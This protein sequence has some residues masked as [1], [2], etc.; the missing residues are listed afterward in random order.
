MPHNYT[1]PTIKTLFAQASS[2]AYPRCNEPLVFEDRGVTTVVAQI[3]HIRSEKL[4]G[5]R[6]DP[7]YA[8]DVN[9]AENL[10]LLCGKH[11]APVDR[12]ES[13]YPVEELQLWKAEQR[14][15]AGGGTPISGPDA[16]AFV[17]LME[18]ER[19]AIAQIARLTT[20]VEIACGKARDALNNVELARLRAIRA[21][22][23]AHGPIR[24]ID[25]D[26]TET[27]IT[28]GIRLPAIEE[29]KWQDRWQTARAASMPNIEAAVGALAEEVAVLRMMNEDVGARATAVLVMAEGASQHVT[30]EDAL[31]QSTQAMHGALRQ[32]WSATQDHS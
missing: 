18:E 15:K 25:E 31:D 19:T 6:H 16:R 32:L 14:A 20:R 2:C 3:A 22:Q 4:D 12:H 13:S 24:A 5:P 27:L 17:G 28:D 7:T 23:A 8:G 26:G 29:G 30:S 10:L 9:G 1:L 21:A 11:H